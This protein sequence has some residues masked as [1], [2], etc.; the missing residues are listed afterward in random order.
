[1]IHIRIPASDKN[2]SVALSDM[3]VDAEVAT[4]SSGAMV[5]ER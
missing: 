1:V 2:P 4:R 5:T 3:F